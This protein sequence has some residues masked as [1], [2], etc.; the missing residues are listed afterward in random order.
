MY[1]ALNRVLNFLHK[2]FQLCFE[3]NIVPS[4]WGIGIINPIQK[5]SCTDSRDP[6][7]YRGGG[8]GN[9]DISSL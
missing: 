3:K 4:Q 1:C 7:G 9:S 5:Q 2:F 8:G 6:A